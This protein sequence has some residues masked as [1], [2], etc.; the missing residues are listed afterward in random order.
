MYAVQVNIKVQNRLA[1]S[2][3]V[4]SLKEWSSYL[5]TS[6]NSLILKYFLD[7]SENQIEI[8][9][10]FESKKLVDKLEKKILIN[11]GMKL[12]RWL[13]MLQEWKDLVKLK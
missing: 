2:S 12:K 9:H 1:K 6:G 4:L 8:F 5:F 7:R 3:I 11:F 10:V 13:V